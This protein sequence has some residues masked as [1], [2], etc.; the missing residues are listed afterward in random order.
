MNLIYYFCFIEVAT[1]SFHEFSIICLFYQAT[2]SFHE[3]NVL[4]L[5]YRT[6]IE[7]AA[8]SFRQFNILFFVLSRLLRVHFI[9]GRDFIGG[10]ILVMSFS[11]WDHV[12]PPYF[13]SDIFGQ[14]NFVIFSFDGHDF[15]DG[16]STW[17]QRWIPRRVVGSP[18][19]ILCCEADPPSGLQLSR[20]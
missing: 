8:V 4:F 2:V 14:F 10:S 17:I 3:F 1:V 7:V 9:G 6:F 15:S 12:W 18:V 13:F 19:W 16:G 11:Q 20:R 5:F